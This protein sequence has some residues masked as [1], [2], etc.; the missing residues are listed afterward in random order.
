VLDSFLH[1]PHR[2]AWFHSVTR[3]SRSIQKSD[4]DNDNDDDDEVILKMLAMSFT[5]VHITSS[6]L[7]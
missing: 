1:L 7:I 3:R 2:S 4:D 6:D 5:S